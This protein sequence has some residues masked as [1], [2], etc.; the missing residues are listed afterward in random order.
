LLLPDER[1]YANIARRII[2]P[3]DDGQSLQQFMSDSPW[4]SARV[5]APRARP[6]AS[7]ST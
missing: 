5:F 7:T 3:D 6:R 4:P 1:N 2:A